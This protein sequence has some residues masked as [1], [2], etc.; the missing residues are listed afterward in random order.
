M[1]TNPKWCQP[2]GA[3]K[4]IFRD[5]VAQP[6]PLALMHASIFFDLRPMYNQTELAAELTDDLRESLRR[7]RGVF[8]FLTHNAL[9]NRPPLSFFRRFVVDRSGEYRNTFDLKLHGLTPVVY[10]ARVLALEAGF[11]ESSHTF[12]RLE[13]AGKHLDGVAAMADSATDAF[14]YLLDMR[15]AHHLR[16]LVEDQKVNDHIDP[17]TLSKTQQRMLRALFATVQEAQEGLSLR[18][19]AHM[20][21]R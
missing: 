21:R 20:M 13:H 19:G 8:A 2:L 14:R 11:L 3:W 9:A 17:A 16:L 4:R 18:H 1:A 10:L 5:W 6:E 7:E 12:A 15:L